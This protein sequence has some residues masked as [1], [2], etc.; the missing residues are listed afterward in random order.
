M[1]KGNTRQV[2]V[3]KPTDTKLFEQ[4]IF[5]M[6]EDALE[7]YGITE[8]RFLEEAHR[9]CASCT[10][11]PPKKGHKH[12]PPFRALAWSGAGAAL[13]GLAWLLSVL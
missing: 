8:A 3:V 6:K 13:T 9:L 4:A 10:E 12:S 11:A 5:L 2:L 1:V 7:K